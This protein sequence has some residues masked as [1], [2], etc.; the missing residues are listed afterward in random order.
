MSQRTLLVT[1][2]NGHLGRRILE[3]LVEKSPKDTKI[4]AGTRDPSKFKPLKGVEAKKVDF[5]DKDLDKA[6]AGVDRLLVVSTDALDRPGRRLEQHKA[7]FAAAKKAGVKHVLYTSMPNPKVGSPVAVAEDHRLSEE[8]LAAGPFGH[9]ILRNNLYMHYQVQSAAA[10]VALGAL[11]TA[12]G[13]GKVAHVTRDD[14]AAAA[15]GAL[16]DGFDGRRI[17]D[18]SG[19]AALSGADVAAI[20]SEVSGKKIAHVALTSAQQRDGLVKAGVPAPIAAVLVSFDEGAAAGDLAVVGT[21]VKDLGG[22]AP[23]DLKTLLTQTKA[24]WLK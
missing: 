10:A 5:E 8:A 15:A 21:A 11:Y 17:V 18:V 3:L 19:P 22:K 1:G 6:F 20:I 24:E 2:A 9:T 4:I 12:T 14:C 7:A 13:D 23:T 16:A